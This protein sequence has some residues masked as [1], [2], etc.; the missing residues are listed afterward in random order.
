MSILQVNAASAVT[1]CNAKA[2][3]MLGYRDDRGVLGRQLTEMVAAG[4]CAA[5]QR[6]L[7]QAL[8]IYMYM[9]AKARAGGQRLQPIVLGGC[10]PA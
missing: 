3:A 2:A 9:L 4:S 6:V 5:V 7:D 10:T 1:V 8:H